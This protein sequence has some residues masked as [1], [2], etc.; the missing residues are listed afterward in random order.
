M[1]QLWKRVRL[2]NNSKATM[3]QDSID[4]KNCSGKNA[5]R[6]LVYERQKL[7]NKCDKDKDG[8]KVLQSL[9]EKKIRKAN[10]VGV[11]P[12]DICLIEES[13]LKI[14]KV[15]NIISLS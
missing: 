4:K 2:T 5:F 10:D 15:R 8:C 14:L 13:P 7:L 3:K 9:A 6:N 11:N 12:E 1:Q